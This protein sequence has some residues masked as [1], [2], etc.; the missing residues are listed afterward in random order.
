MSDPFRCWLV[1][2]VSC[3]MS[4]P[5]RAFPAIYC[6]FVIMC[7]EIFPAKTS[8]SGTFRNIQGLHRIDE[9]WTGI[10]IPRRAVCSGAGVS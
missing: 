9:M 3:I 7:L 10:L 2:D 4:L 1:T 5:G 8:C 6:C